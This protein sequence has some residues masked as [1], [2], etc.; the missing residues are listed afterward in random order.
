MHAP[1]PDTG[2]RRLLAV[3]RES[4]LRARLIA[5]DEGALVELIDVASPWLLGMVTGMLH[6]PAEA[7]EV[8]LDAFRIAWD[9][10]GTLP[11]EQDQR[12][13]PW[14]FRVARNRAI[15]RLRAGRRRRIKAERIE[16]FAAGVGGSVAPVEPDEAA[17]PGWHVHRQVHDAIA[18]LPP[19]QENAVRLAFFRGLTHSEI[20]AELE[21]P[22]GTVKTRLRL[23]YDKLRVALEP[24]KDWIA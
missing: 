9:K 21:V 19:D 20:A 11:A 13:L 7:E 6:D 3:E 5:R 15:D 22:L 16:G 1:A 2:G 14:L 8:V 23:A 24:L 4:S 10:V 12:L 18:A 17:Q